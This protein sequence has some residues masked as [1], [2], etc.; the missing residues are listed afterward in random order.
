MD[1]SARYWQGANVYQT[2]ISTGPYKLAPNQI[3]LTQRELFEAVHRRMRALAGFHASDVDDLAQV[4]AEQVFRKLP[5]FHG[6]SD[7]MTWV[8][9]VCYRVLLNQRR[10]YRRWS[11]RFLVQEPDPNAVADAPLPGVSL[12]TRER[13]QSLNTAL[14]AMSEKYR[15]VVVLHDLEELSVRDIAMIVGCSELTVRSRLRDGRKR[16]RSLL[17]ADEIFNHGDRHE[18]THY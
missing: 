1:R 15:A 7:L 14:A 4:A 16:L 18:L 17:E 10:W 2:E 3:T 11:L 5:T 9:G 8:Y 12:E 13:I 6:H